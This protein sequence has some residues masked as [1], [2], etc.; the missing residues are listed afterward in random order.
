MFKYINN[1]KGFTL[2]ELFIV[3]IGLVTI[4]GSIALIYIAVHFI[5]K[6]W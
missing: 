3:L 2:T 1:E 4:V 6:F 5:L